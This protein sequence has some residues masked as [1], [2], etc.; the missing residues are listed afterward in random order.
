MQFTLRLSGLGLVLALCWMLSPL[1]AA[2]HQDS[3]VAKAN[4]DLDL[5]DV[6]VFRSPANPANLVVALDIMSVFDFVGGSK[7]GKLFAED[8]V[9][10]LSVDRDGDLRPDVIVRFKFFTGPSGQ[11]FQMEGLTSTPVIGDVTPPGQGATPFITQ[12]QA[13]EKILVFCGPRDDPFFFDSPAFKDF[14]GPNGNYTGPGSP[15]LPSAGLRRPGTG[16]PANSFKGNVAAIV[17]EAPIKLYT[18][19][20]DPNVGKIK[21]WAKTFRVR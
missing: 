1:R 7:P 17:V 18:G 5:T 4:A 3:P 11:K 9:Y 15:Y 14:E 2:D 8:G 13:P 16:A 12:V 6:Y 10:E 19:L 20:P 21:I